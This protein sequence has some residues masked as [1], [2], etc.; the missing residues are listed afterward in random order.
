MTLTKIIIGIIILICGIAIR[1]G[2]ARIPTGQ[3]E[4]IKKYFILILIS[5][6]VIGAVLLWMTNK[7]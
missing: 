5:A 3:N 2:M 4:K 6:L 7:N 1:M